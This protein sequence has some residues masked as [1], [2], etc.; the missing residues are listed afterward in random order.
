MGK[1]IP[2]NRRE[3]DAKYRAEH[4]EERNAASRAWR[5]A[6]P[7]AARESSR[8]HAEKRR[9]YCA[10]YRQTE[11]GKEVRQRGQAKEIATGRK[12]AREAVRRAVRSGRLVRVPCHC[13]NAQ[14]EAHHHRGYGEHRLDV[15]WLCRTHHE[16]EHHV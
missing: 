7:H 4:R 5:A 13:G 12:A 15:M 3:Y 16:A 2:E 1:H 8:K 10:G 6:H 11:A 9:L 14:T